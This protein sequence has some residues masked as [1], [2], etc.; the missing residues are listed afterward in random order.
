MS[1]YVA[2]AA[3]LLIL[4]F[5]F[6][7][8]I[9]QH[10]ALSGA[11]WIPL[12]W[13]FILGSRNLSAWLGLGASRIVDLE[14]Y[15]E[16]N[17]L[18]RNFLIILII[19]S[20]IVLIR[21]KLP[22]R[23]ILQRNQVLLYFLLF[24]L[25]SILWSEFPLVA[26][27]RFVKFA[28]SVTIIL[29]ILSER[30]P[31]E[32]ALAVLRRI[33]YLVI[34][35]SV[36]FIRYFPEYGRYYHIWTYEVGYSGACVYKNQLGVACI[37]AAVVFLWELVREF[38]RKRKPFSSVEIWTILGMLA[39]TAYLTKIANSATAT[40]CILVGILLILGT[41]LPLAKRRPATITK[42]IS[43]VF[44]ASAL[45]QAAFN[46][47]DKIIVALG[48]NPSLTGRV[49]LWNTLLGMANNPLI[50]TGY[51]SFWTIDRLTYIWGLGYTAL[52]AHNGY[53][54]T[55]LNLGLVGVAFFLA[56]ILTY[57]K[58]T[59][60][61]FLRDYSFGQIKLAF[62]IIFILYNFTEAA[63]PRLGLL[64]LVFLMFMI[65]VPQRASPAAGETTPGT[66]LDS[67]LLIR[68]SHSR[69]PLIP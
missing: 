8:D 53:I 65:E 34:C 7:L 54:D 18:D 1:S 46:I 23:E 16:G 38:G 58:N 6:Y 14:A 60:R 21:R 4:A 25:A 57:F 2:L 49:P 59:G 31:F 24:C 50:G 12:V 48:R 69:M 28:G 35:L 56:L 10:P 64:L 5:L 47:K 3:C 52:Q 20:A 44:L 62:F 19:L 29:V 39:M 55:Y 68:D 17:S 30:S 27:K 42:W 51:E 67:P 61:E 36:L 26:F 33:S 63:F 43:G 40:F 11:L 32:A 37:I 15:Q 45:L 9:K 22:W 13:L 41:N 66:I